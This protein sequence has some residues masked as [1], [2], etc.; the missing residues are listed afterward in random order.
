MAPVIQVFA[1]Y[2][3]IF[4]C[5]PARWLYLTDISTF[6]C[7]HGI[8]SYRS[9]CHT[10]PSQRIQIPI[11]FKRNIGQICVGKEGN[12]VINCNIR[13]SRISRDRRQIKCPAVSSLGSCRLWCL[14]C[15]YSH[16][17]CNCLCCLFYSCGRPRS[18]CLST[19]AN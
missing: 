13:L 7:R 16:A 6:L 4:Y 19:G 3:V 1:I 12:I 17:F 5:M 14:D 2:K 9:I 10:A 8:R 18:R 11:T 15:F